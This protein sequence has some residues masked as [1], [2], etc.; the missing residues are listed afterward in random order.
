MNK[1]LE[2]FSSLRVE[3]LLQ[4]DDI[5]SEDLF[6]IDAGLRVVFAY[7]TMSS[8]LYFDRGSPRIEK[9]FKGKV[10]QLRD[11]FSLKQTIKV[12]F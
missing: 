9:V 6:V 7:D 1:L 5:L 8:L 2:D 11:V 4:F 10:L 12:S 3:I